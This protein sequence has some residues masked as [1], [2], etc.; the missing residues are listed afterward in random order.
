MAVSEEHPAQIP[1]AARDEPERGPAEME[2]PED[3]QATLMKEQFERGIE[4]FKKGDFL[5]AVE[6]FT[7]I[8]KGDPRNPRAWSYLSLALSKVPERVKEAEEALLRAIHL[9][10]S[11]SDHLANLGLLYLKAGLKARAK[12]QFEKALSLDPENMR[13]KRGLEQTN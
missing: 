2:S 9:D 3:T 1:V 7:W 5:S 4:E 11:N 12:R 13:A 8:T 6:R 10:P